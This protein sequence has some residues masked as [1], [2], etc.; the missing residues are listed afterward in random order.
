MTELEMKVEALIRCTPQTAYKKALAEV[1]KSN[2][3]AS[4]NLEDVVRE[5]IREIGMPGHIKGFEYTVCAVAK[6]YENPELNRSMYKGL[7][8]KVAEK[9]GTTP[10]RAERCIRHGVEVAWSR[11]GS[12]LRDSYFDAIIDPRKANPMTKEFLM[13]MV[14]IVRQKMR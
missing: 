3:P 12:D 6:L 8:A 2:P 11:Y 1:R 10:T 5:T 7:Y 9:F 13:G 14:D 4:Q